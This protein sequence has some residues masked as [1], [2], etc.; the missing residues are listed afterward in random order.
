MPVCL[1]LSSPSLSPPL[2]PS[3]P[4]LL[5]LC[6][7]CS[8]TQWLWTNGE[9]TSDIH[10]PYCPHPHVP[11][12][13]WTSLAHVELSELWSLHPQ[14]RW[15]LKGDLGMLFKVWISALAETV[16]L[17]SKTALTSQFHTEQGCKLHLREQWGGENQSV[18]TFCTPL[19]HQGGQVC[20]FASSKGRVTASP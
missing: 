12:H 14:S 17:F 15:L 18:L 7:C 4:P 19:R 3:S 1:F 16:H 20:L 2:S 6:D 5:L 13:H 11:C 10:V 8:I 9:V